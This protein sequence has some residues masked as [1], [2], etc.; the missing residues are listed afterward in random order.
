[1]SLLLAFPLA[2]QAKWWIF[3]ASEEEVAINYLYLNQMSYEEAGEKIRLFRETMPDG[4]LT[5]RG[6]A[7]VRR[8]TIGG[9]FV[10][11]D[12]KATWERAKLAED[13]TFIYSFKPEMGKTYILHVRVID[14]R[15]RTNAV[16]G[17]RKEVTLDEGNITAAV[18]EV[19][20]HL[21]AAYRNEDAARF[22][23][24][25]SDRFAGDAANLE[26]A[27]R[28]DFAALMDISLSY[29]INNVVA[30]QR[31]RVQVS[32]NYSRMAL[33]IRGGGAFRDSGTTEFGFISQAGGLN[34]VSMKFPLLFGLSDASEV[35]T[36]LVRM[37]GNEEVL[38]I[39]PA[40]TVQKL[41]FDQ[42]LKSIE[43]GAAV[44]GTGILTSTPTTWFESF[45]FS[46][47]DKTTEIWANAC[48]GNISGDFGVYGVTHHVSVRTGVTVID[49]GI[50]SLDDV[51][52]APAGGY[53][54]PH[55]T[56]GWPQG[57]GNPPPPGSLFRFQTGRSYVFK[58][59]GN[60]YGALEITNK[61]GNAIHFK[62]KHSSSGAN[63]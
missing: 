16:E 40:G 13:G 53:V 15:G 60:A 26:R 4:L 38:V 10:S 18:R 27:I 34:L 55:T 56:C 12:D 39:S 9:V 28:K 48:N 14:T 23:A 50:K 59:P 3:G 35:A 2:G 11:L 51:L 24:R 6:K 1:V 33:P 19:L 62:Y 44:V 37:A 41:K 29:S 31:G 63:F 25:V 42:A 8:G 30:D 47:G 20:D 5:L 49:L 45:S 46:M 32:L 43:A 21:V 57:S 61:V 17:T 36:G 7:S 22:M 52:V 58:L 54:N